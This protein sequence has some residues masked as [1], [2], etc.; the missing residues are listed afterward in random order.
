M[1]AIGKLDQSTRRGELQGRDMGFEFERLSGE[2]IGAGVDVDRELGPECLESVYHT[3]IRVALEQ[4]RIPD[5]S[6]ATSDVAFEGVPVGRARVDLV[7]DGAL[8]LEIKAV[9]ALQDVHF[10]QLRSCLKAG[11]IQAGLLMNF[12]AGRLSIRRVVRSQP[13]PITP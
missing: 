11:G 8:V 10:A 13:N 3:A 12:N 1:S 6:Q 4:R 2:V 5:Q 9:H 7:V